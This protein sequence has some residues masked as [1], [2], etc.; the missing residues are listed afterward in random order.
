MLL[1]KVIFWLLTRNKLSDGAK[2]LRANGL[3]HACKLRNVQ[4]RIHVQL[5]SL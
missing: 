1:D 5:S 4:P 2:Q 3:K